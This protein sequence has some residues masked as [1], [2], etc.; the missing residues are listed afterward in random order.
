MKPI[1]VN[2]PADTPISAARQTLGDISSELA[3]EWFA[4]QLINTFDH[5][6]LYYQ[7]SNGQRPGQLIVATQEPEGF[8]LAD[9]RR[10]SP[11][12]TVENAQAFIREAMNSLPILPM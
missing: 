12:W 5:Y 11:G 3:R 4:D 6:H 2:I 10:L 1:E 8:Q 7:P 9:A